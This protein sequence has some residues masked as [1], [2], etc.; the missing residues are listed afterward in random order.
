[1]NEHDQERCYGTQRLN[2]VQS[3]YSEC[4]AFV[5][6]RGA[7]VELIA[8][9]CRAAIGKG[10]TTVSAGGCGHERPCKVLRAMSISVNWDTASTGDWH[11]PDGR[12]SH[13]LELTLELL[14]ACRCRIMPGDG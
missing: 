5:G 4:F 14:A 8:I 3:G 1:M 2:V 7:R 12:K 9:N 11:S 6:V 13:I 10:V